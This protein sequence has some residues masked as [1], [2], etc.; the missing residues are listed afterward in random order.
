MSPDAISSALDTAWRSDRPAAAV[1]PAGASA[2][3]DTALAN[4]RTAGASRAEPSPRQPRGA[5]PHGGVDAERACRHR[6]H[7]MAE[8]VARPLNGRPV[9][10]RLIAATDPGRECLSGHARCDRIVERRRSSPARSGG[11][12]SRPVLQAPGWAGAIPGVLRRTAVGGIACARL[13]RRVRGPPDPDPVLIAA[14][15]GRRSPRRGTAPPRLRSPRG[16]RRSATAGSPDGSRP[17]RPG[18]SAAA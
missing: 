18:R 13:R 9:K 12:S 8:F 16:D 1:S 7:R 15:P 17:R 2:A 4:R 3:G 14:V 5:T 10:W 6:A 11:S